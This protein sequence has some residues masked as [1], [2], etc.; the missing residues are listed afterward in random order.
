[1]WLYYYF[2][3]EKNYEVLESKIACILFEH[4]TLI[5]MEQNRKW[6]ISHT[7]LERRT[8]ASALIRIK[9]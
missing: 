1:M 9:H 7:V 2:N 8:F 6:R 3:F 4:A 5:K